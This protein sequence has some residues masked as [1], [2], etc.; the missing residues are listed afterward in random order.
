[1]TGKT[2]MNL[3]DY[4]LNNDEMMDEKTAETLIISR[5][6]ASVKEVT[7]AME[8][9][10]TPF[11]KTMMKQVLTHLREL[12]ER[13]EEMDL[14]IDTYM[15]EYW[16]AIKKL[17]QI[18]GIGKKSAEIILAEIGLDMNQFPSAGHLASWAG[19]APGN[20]E[21]AGKRKS[22]RTRKGNKITEIDTR[23]SGEI[24]F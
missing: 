11:Q 2:T 14:I 1:M 15:A 21:S 23:S 12:S 16:E 8:G 10:M 5:I 9:I 3:L 24:S 6:S 13:I 18:P 7:E 20:N 17:E 22:G 19:V 4:V